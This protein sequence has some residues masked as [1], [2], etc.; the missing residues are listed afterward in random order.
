[1]SE[2]LIYRHASG[3]RPGQVAPCRM[4]VANRDLLQVPLTVRN[5]VYDVAQQSAN[6]NMGR[7]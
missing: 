3:Q 6:R 5:E 2:G 7:I 4:G 1:M